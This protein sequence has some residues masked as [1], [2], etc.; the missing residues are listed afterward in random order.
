MIG[1]GAVGWVGS[2]RAIHPKAAHYKWSLADYPDLHPQEV[3]FSSRT[4][5]TVAARFIPSEQPGARRASIVL[6]HG[7]GDN[8]EQ[9]L[10]WAEFL[11]QAGFGILTYDMRSRG[12]TEAPAVTLGALE[13]LDLV[14]AVDYLAGRPDLD[15]GRIGAFGVSMGGATSLLA[16]AQDQRIKAVVDDSGFSDAPNVI[17]VS[18]E[19]F[20]G[21]PA[22][23]FAPITV[24]IAGW[25]A[26]ADVRAV[27]PVDHVAEIAPRPILIIHCLGDTVVPPD[28]SIRILAAAR[29]PKQIWW[30]PTGKHIQGHTVARAEYER[31]V[32]DFFDAA[33]Q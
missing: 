24:A 17:A 20:I 7:Y 1:L 16:A 19:H 23:P 18:F 6:S 14:S 30:V 15:S 9:M 25:R 5:I 32:V 33:L 10:P 21:L 11:H 8:Q 12:K 2:E 28:N 27:R 29:E 4:H 3:R 13:Q 26:G 22:F 31:R